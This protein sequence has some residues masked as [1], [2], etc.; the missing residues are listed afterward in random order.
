MARSSFLYYIDVGVRTLLYNKFGS[1]LGIDTQNSDISE[2][3]N[4]GVL[5]ISKSVAQR[6]VAEKRGENY[7]EFINVFRTQESFDWKYNRTSVSRRGM[8]VEGEDGK[9]YQVTGVPVNLTYNFWLWSRDLDS[10]NACTQQYLFWQQV[11]PKFDII[12]DGKFPLSFDLHFGSSLD[13]SPLDSIFDKGKYFVKR[14]GLNIDGWLFDYSELTSGKISKIRLSL[15]DSKE[16]ISPEISD[17]LV[18][19][20]SYDQELSD[21]VR[22]FRVEMYGIID[23]NKLENAVYLL[24]DFVSDFTLGQKIVLENSKSNNGVYCI[25]SVSLDGENTKIIFEDSLVDDDVSGNIFI[26]ES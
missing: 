21:A 26:S 20:S 19:D 8:A 9:V 7:L 15:Y 14:F 6:L 3:I 18:E 16:L 5:L 13:E 2:N 25:K 12:F 1:F 24:N 17:I 4:K 22:M 23:V 11:Y 10:I